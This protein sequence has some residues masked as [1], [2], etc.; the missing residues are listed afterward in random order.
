MK[1]EKST[2]CML[3]SACFA[4]ALWHGTV[5]AERKNAPQDLPGS[6]VADARWIKGQVDEK[7]PLLIV[8]SRIKDEYME[9]HLPGAVHLN[10]DNIDDYKHILPADRDHPVLFYCNG[11]KCLMSHKAA[12]LA[13]QLGYRNVYWFRGGIPEWSGLGYPLE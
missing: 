12:S 5:S 10:A 13:L 7:K 2:I 6:T 9:G 8:D 1:R 11:P 3:A 4:L